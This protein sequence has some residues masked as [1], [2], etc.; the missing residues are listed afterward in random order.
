MSEVKAA[1]F[2]GKKKGIV[3]DVDTAKFVEQKG[4]KVTKGKAVKAPKAEKTEAPKKTAKAPSKREAATKKAEK[5]S[6]GRPDIFAGKSIKVLKK[7]VTAREG[8]KRADWL[9]AVTSSKTVDEARGKV[10]G[11][12]SSVLRWMEQEGIASFK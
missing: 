1:K 6:A 4:E 11:L 7:D 12:D 8:T 2:A 10:E 3:V 9:N 5:A